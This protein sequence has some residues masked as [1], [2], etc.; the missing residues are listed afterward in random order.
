MVR[1]RCGLEFTKVI[2]VDTEEKEFP[3]ANSDPDDGRRIHRNS[4][5]IM[6]EASEGKTLCK[7]LGEEHKM[8]MNNLPLGNRSQ[9]RKCIQPQSES[10]LS[11]KSSYADNPKRNRPLEVF[12]IGGDSDAEDVDAYE[13]IGDQLLRGCEQMHGVNN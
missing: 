7:K 6:H 12:H 3:E 5:S 1:G 9:K 2:P 8:E 4:Q 10:A 13:E 11:P